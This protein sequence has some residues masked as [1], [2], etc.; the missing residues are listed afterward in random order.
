MADGKNLKALGSKLGETEKERFLQRALEK[1]EDGLKAEEKKAEKKEE[2]AH[3]PQPTPCCVSVSEGFSPLTTLFQI[4]C[5]T[6]LRQKLRR[7]H[8]LSSLRSGYGTRFAPPDRAA[9]EAV[10]SVEQQR[11]LE[12]ALVTESARA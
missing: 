2:F 9:E 6:L 8:F 4:V 5:Q 3:A 11:S 10:W 7:R 1:K 12:A